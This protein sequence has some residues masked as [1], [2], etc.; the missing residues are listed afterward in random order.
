MQ[1]DTSYGFAGIDFDIEGEGTIPDEDAANYASLGRSLVIDRQTSQLR[2]WLIDD[3]DEIDRHIWE[4]D[5]GVLIE[6]IANGPVNRIIITIPAALTE[7]DEEE[8]ILEFFMESAY[9]DLRRPPFVFLSFAPDVDPGKTYY[10]DAQQNALLNNFVYLDEAVDEDIDPERGYTREM[11]SLAFKEKTSG[12][13]EKRQIWLDTSGTEFCTGKLRLA[14]QCQYGTKDIEPDDTDTEISLPLTTYALRNRQSTSYALYSGSATQ[15]DYWILTI[16]SSTVT[17]QQLSIPDDF[18][19][20]FYDLLA[21]AD[22]GDRNKIEGY[23]LSVASLGEVSI[24]ASFDPVDGTTF[25][26]GWK[27]NWLGTE[28]AIVTNEPVLDAIDNPLYHIQ[29]LYK[30][31]IEITQDDDGDYQLSVTNTKSEEINCTPEN[32]VTVVWH[33]NFILNEMQTFNWH[34]VSGYANGPIDESTA[35]LYAFYNSDDELVV[36]RHFLETEKSDGSNASELI[37]LRAAFELDQTVC[38][39]GELSNDAGWAITFTS[40]GVYVDVAGVGAPSGG[41]AKTFAYFV[42]F[43]MSITENGNTNATAP[44]VPPGFT[45]TSTPP[46]CGALVDLSWRNPAFKYPILASEIDFSLTRRRM[47]SA[48]ISNDTAFVI[49]WGDEAAYLG[50]LKGVGGL[51]FYYDG[52]HQKV[53][54]VVSDLTGAINGSQFAASTDG[55]ITGHGLGNDTIV[56]NSSLHGTARE[57]QEYDVEFTLHS[58]HGS[59]EPVTLHVESFHSSDHDEA[60]DQAL[61]QLGRWAGIFNPP[62]IADNTFTPILEVQESVGGVI[63]FTDDVNASSEID[64]TRITDEE[65]PD[66]ATPLYDGVFVGWV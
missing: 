41:D 61:F 21:E 54:K 59:Q 15:P 60:N 7:E 18:V 11:D 42:D 30:L 1:R 45:A 27:A 62:V 50:K 34:H 16:S 57:E 8:I 51:A 13:G 44:A 64:R 4:L 28:L 49:P 36:F 58:K 48:T 46:Y 19:D 23:M 3:Y 52:T 55:G 43:D 38:I 17:A 6:S 24:S 47:N 26:Y 31:S 33:P 25:E 65:L 2:R 66:D 9:V 40:S 32:G 5:N 20:Q 39:E 63:L 29:R 14:V 37:S 22:E 56:P 35:P 12:I 10:P 53:N